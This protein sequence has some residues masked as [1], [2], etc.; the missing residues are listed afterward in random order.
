MGSVGVGGDFAAE[1]VSV[2]DD[3]LHFFERVLR[4]LRIVAEREHAA[5]GADLDEVGSVLDVLADL[6]L[7]SG[8]AIGHAVADGVDIRRAA[9]CCRSVRR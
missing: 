1:A 7:H 6:V 8:D 4:G 3:G 2:G 9:C 5:G